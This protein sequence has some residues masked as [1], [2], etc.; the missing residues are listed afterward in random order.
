M[1]LGSAICEILEF[2]G[3]DVIR[4]NYIG[5]IGLHVIKWLWN[6]LNFHKGEVPP[7]EG[8]T[9]WMGG[10]YAEAVKKI[11]DNLEYET[12]VREALG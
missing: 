11:D 6:Y 10:L 3:D 5:D 9:G 7:L 2:S 1:V 12:Q 8:K 4:A